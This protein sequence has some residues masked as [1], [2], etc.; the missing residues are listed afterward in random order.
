VPLGESEISVITLGVNYFI[1]DNV[2]FTADWGIN[3]ESSLAGLNERN[4]ENLGWGYSNAP[5]QWVLRAQL[6]LLF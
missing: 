1:N 5:D 4:V 2:K 3:L 6:Q